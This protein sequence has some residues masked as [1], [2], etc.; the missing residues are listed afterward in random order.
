MSDNTAKHVK[1]ESPAHSEEDDEDSE[2]IIEDSHP[3]FEALAKNKTK[4]AKYM[5]K[6]NIV[7]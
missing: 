4:V 2:V 3:T 6:K 7:K 1:P 5:K